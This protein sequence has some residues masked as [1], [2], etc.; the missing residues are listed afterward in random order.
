MPFTAKHKAAGMNTPGGHT[1]YQVEEVRLAGLG[2]GV[3]VVVPPHAH[4]L[5]GVLRILLQRPAE[6]Q[7]RGVLGGQQPLRSMDEGLPGLAHGRGEHRR[8][9]LH[10][11]A[12]SLCAADGCKDPIQGKRGAD[13]MFRSLTIVLLNQGCIASWIQDYP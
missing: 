9:L 5:A 3:V 2:E 10:A 8:L 6:A 11:L 1:A 12:P 13:I 4:G 7:L